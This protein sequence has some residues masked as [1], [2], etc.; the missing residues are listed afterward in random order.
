VAILF[1]RR[2]RYIPLGR[3]YVCDGGT[4][5]NVTLPESFTDRGASPAAR[6]LT[7]DVLT[8]LA[9]VVSALQHDLTT[10]SGGPN[11]V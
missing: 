6:P 1:E 11:L 10:Q 7:A 9:A 5:G 4:L 3:V 2:Y 8:D